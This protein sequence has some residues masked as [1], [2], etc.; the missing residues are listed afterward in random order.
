MIA[1]TLRLGARAGGPADDWLAALPILAA[2]RAAEPEVWVAFASE[3]DAA[4]VEAG[5][6][7]ARALVWLCEDTPP[8]T[9]GPTEEVH[10]C[11]DP[12]ARL[13]TRAALAYARAQ[14]VGSPLTNPCARRTARLERRN[15]ALA[16]ALDR[17]LSMANHDLRSPLAVVSG[18]CQL[19]EENL[20]AP[21]QQRRAVDTIRRQTDRIA[22]MT[23]AALDAARRA[24]EA[25]GEMALVSVPEAAREVIEALESDA[26]AR[27]VRVTVRAT[28]ASRVHAPP[29]A[30]RDALYALVGDAV[31]AA[32]SG[33]EVLVRADDSDAGTAGAPGRVAVEVLGAGVGPR[34]P[35]V[36]AAKQVPG[37]RTVA[38]L[39]EAAGVAL[40]AEPTA[41]AP[42]S[43]WFSLPRAR[44]LA[45]PERLDPVTGA[46]RLA[47]V[48]LEPGRLGVLVDLL[49]PIAVRRQYGWVGAEQLA[50][51]VAGE[52][53]ARADDGDVL[54]RVAQDSFVL[55]RS[56]RDDEQVLFAT[57][58]RES[59]SRARPRVG[60]LRA[61]PK[62]DVR[63]VD[64]D[65]DLRGA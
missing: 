29:A 26:A 10:L 20:L 35:S 43:V 54:V 42:W 1:R 6:A 27:A 48:A 49:D 28:A 8:P 40:R 39:L 51:W 13:V 14:Q 5:A 15:A 46:W 3:G 52:L 37:L 31:R 21:A 56:D 44:P 23:A 36:D 18:H 60:L 55:V 38:R 45:A 22:Q 50:I 63:V 9:V 17:F 64:V 58:L 16:D 34:A 19:L 7:G 11:A 61:A 4:R 25:D 41:A 30:F 2:A 57:Q 53:R 33:T 65:R 47:A 24:L 59:L 12:P 32:P 62:F